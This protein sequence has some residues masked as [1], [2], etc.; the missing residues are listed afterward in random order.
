MLLCHVMLKILYDGDV[1]I[2]YLEMDWWDLLDKGRKST[3][4]SCFPLVLHIFYFH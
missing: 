2:L 3:E 1:E 4:V